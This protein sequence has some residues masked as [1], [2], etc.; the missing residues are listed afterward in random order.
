M[1]GAMLLT[2]TLTPGRRNSCASS[3]LSW[4][5]AAFDTLY[6]KW[7]CDV[8]VIPDMDEIPDMEEDLEE[9]EDEA[10]AAPKTAAP[11]SGAAET[12]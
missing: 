10:T 7:F 12:G 11:S 5:A 1:P 6:L 4:I 3:W 9:G 8:R 2:R